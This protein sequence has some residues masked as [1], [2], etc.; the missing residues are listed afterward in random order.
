MWK[1]NYLHASID[2]I[3]FL[4]KAF[5]Q[6]FENVVVE[7]VELS[8]YGRYFALFLG[9][10]D[11]VLNVLDRKRESDRARKVKVNPL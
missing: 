4:V 8:I 7:L 3:P 11:G 5:I 9:L 2:S 10:N 1:K 6:N